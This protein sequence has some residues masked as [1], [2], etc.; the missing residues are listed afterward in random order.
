[1]NDIHSNSELIAADGKQRPSKSGMQN[2]PWLDETLRVSQL[3]A[4]PS[5]AYVVDVS[6]IFRL[7]FFNDFVLHGIVSQFAKPRIHGLQMFHILHLSK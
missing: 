5:S 6:S 1:M 3:H 7:H 4:L 2:L